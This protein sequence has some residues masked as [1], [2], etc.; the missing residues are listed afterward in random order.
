MIFNYFF[1]LCF[2]FFSF[3]NFSSFS[4]TPQTPDMDISFSFF[5]FFLDSYDLSFPTPVISLLILAQVSPTRRPF[6]EREKYRKVEKEKFCGISSSCISFHSRQVWILRPETH[7]QSFYN[8]GFH[9]DYFPRSQRSLTG[10]LRINFP[11]FVII[12]RG[13]LPLLPLPM[14]TAKTNGAFMGDCP[15]SRYRGRV[16]LLVT[17]RSQGIKNHINFRGRLHKHTT[18][19]TCGFSWATFNS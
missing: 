5:F 14:A 18:E 9:C 8:P 13:E 12:K 17:L 4:F 19:K 3:S 2:S 6:L 15:L 11:V 10:F 7:L 16:K 1:I